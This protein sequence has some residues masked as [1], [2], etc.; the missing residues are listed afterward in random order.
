MPDSVPSSWI[1]RIRGRARVEHLPLVLPD[2]KVDVPKND[3]RGPLIVWNHRWE[4]DKNPERFFAALFSLSESGARF[5]VAVCGQRFE[6]APP[7]FDEARSRL[8]DRVEH[9]GPIDD[10]DA[11]WHLL[12][13][14][15]LYTSP[16][17]RDATLSRMPSSA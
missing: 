15:L 13:A 1:D 10:R 17:P 12:R 5:R 7:I 16:S 2:V 3:P 6:Q 4:H 11:Y 14:C 8:G 9:F